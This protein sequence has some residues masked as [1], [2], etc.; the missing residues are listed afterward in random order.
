L[1]AVQAAREAAR[2][3]QCTNNLRQIAL[4]MLSYENR[5][6]CFPPAYIPDKNGKPMHS[7]RVLIL[8]YLE[9]TDLYKQ[10]R[11]NE[12]WN[13]PHNRA[14]AAQMPRTYA[15]PD[16]YSPGG[17]MTSYAMLVGPHAF[18]P[19]PKGR[20]VSE[21]RDGTANTLMVAE[22]ADSQVNWMEPKDIDAEQMPPQIN[23]RHS[24]GNPGISSHH[25]RGANVA[26]CDGSVQSLSDSIDPQTLKRLITID[27]GGA[28]NR[29]DF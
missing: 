7:W 23:G 29:A 11:F 21:I 24:P 10:Y 14:L 5:Y 3:A 25:P 4:A 16:D 6:G 20:K 9:R 27:D 8:P 12:P 18:S 15:C 17:E 1:P 13:S 19:G 22:V 26:F 2:R 28:I